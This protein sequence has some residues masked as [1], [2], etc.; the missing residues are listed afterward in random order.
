MDN[1]IEK[2][3]EEIVEEIKTESQL[4][5][6]GEATDSPSKNKFPIWIIPIAISVIIAIAMAI[7]LPEFFANQ[8]TGPVYKDYTVTVVDTAGNP[9]SNVIVKFTTPSGDTKTKVTGKDGIASL[10]NS[11][12]GD[13]QVVLERGFSDA[14]IEKSEFVLTK[15]VNTIKIAVRDETNTMELY[16]DLS[17]TTYGQH[18]SAGSFN[19]PCADAGMYYFVFNAPQSGVYKISVSSIDSDITV[20][21][22]GIPMF[23][24]ST[25]RGEGEYDGKTFELVIQDTATPYVI[26][27]NVTMMCEAQLVIER[28]G[29]APLDPNYVSWVEVPATGATF[30][31]C[32]LSG[33][34]MVD[35]DIAD[36]D[37]KAVLGNDGIYRTLDGKVIYIRITTASTVGRINEELQFVPVL[38]GSLALLA[39]H[40]DANI[41]I[42]VGGHVY[43]DQGNFVNKYRYNEMIKSYMDLADDKYGVVP[44]TD[45]LA[46][47]IKL[48]GESNGWYNITSPGYL[49]D[50]IVVEPEISWLF[51][52]M[53]EQ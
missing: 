38:S 50:G 22:Y 32:D 16:G 17:D 35:V 1:N 5:E 47:C 41:G 42:N 13:Y 4:K 36:A 25:H 45:E 30:E 48:H 28:T 11:I 29:E 15:D 6:V 27:I 14:I 7:V 44:L 26:G 20:G 2:N 24:Q 33:K 3:N 40:V 9:M 21:F 51:L 19:I 34:T 37:F 31:K 53:V 12:E 52:C 18:I 10:P 23:V 43:D 49:F 46:E 8:E 39:G